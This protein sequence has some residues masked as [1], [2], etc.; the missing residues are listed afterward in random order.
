[1]ENR[2]VCLGLQSTTADPLTIKIVNVQRH[3]GYRKG[4]RSS[5]FKS[6]NHYEN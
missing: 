1:M 2:R 5:K 3:E 4:H 6:T